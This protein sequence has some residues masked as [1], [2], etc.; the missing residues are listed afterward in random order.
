MNT[1][2]QQ[3]HRKRYD[4][5]LA[6]IL[7]II[8]APLLADAAEQKTVGIE[9]ADAPSYQIGDSWTYRIVDHVYGGSTSA[10]LNGDYKIQLLKEGP[11]FVE[12]STG[13]ELAFANAGVL[14][15]MQPTKPIREAPGSFF[16]F[17]LVVA[18]A[19]K[20][21]FYSKAFGRWIK[22]E[23]VVS[24]I[25]TVV[26]PAGNLAAFRLERRLFLAPSSCQFCDK[27]KF[28]ISWVYFYSPQTKSV[29]KYRYQA[30]QKIDNGHPMVIRDIQAELV[31]YA[32]SGS[33]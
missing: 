18:K 2:Y 32:L 29:V 25:E 14:T 4:A 20:D 28:S 22:P 27:K 26:T 6:L 19:W 7:T 12:L 30:E 31:N 17:P 33:Q 10:Q 5:R 11:K 1:G 21:D 15:V 9:Q 8:L 16:R 24:G 23:V 13:D 3:R